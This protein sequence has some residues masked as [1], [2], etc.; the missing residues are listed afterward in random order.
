L[1]SACDAYISLHRGE[2]FGLGIAEAMLFAKPVIVT[3]WSASTEFC[4]EQTSIPIPYTLTPIDPSEF[5]IL[6]YKGVTNWA[7]PDIDAAAVA[8]R[9]LY[10]DPTLRQTLGKNGKQFIEEHFSAENF[11]KSINEFLNS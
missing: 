4:D 6:P 9:R 5:S 2:G 3:D 7:E 1:T 8:L 11:K 10:D